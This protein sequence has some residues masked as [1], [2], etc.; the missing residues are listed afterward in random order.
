MNH[1]TT[2]RRV[3][4]VRFEPHRRTACAA[5]TE[6]VGAGFAGASF[7][8]DDLL[9]FRSLSFG[10]HV[11]LG[12]PGSDGQMVLRD[13]APRALDAKARELTTALAIP[14]TAAVLNPDP[15]LQG[16]IP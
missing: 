15:L 7:T 8:G 11:K 14:A 9:D 10:D 4:R 1:T 3:E 6:P 16:P 12:L 13:V 2:V 5:H